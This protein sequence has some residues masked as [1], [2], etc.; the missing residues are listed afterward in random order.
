MYVCAYVYVGVEGETSGVES[1]GRHLARA[2][3]IQHAALPVFAL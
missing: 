3:V 2:K 1:L